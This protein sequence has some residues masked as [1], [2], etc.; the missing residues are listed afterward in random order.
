M[1]IYKTAVASD[2]IKII[3]ELANQIW[4]EHYPSIISVEQIEYMIS[5]RFTDETV[6]KHL[7]Q[8]II[9]EIINDGNRDIGY[10]SYEKDDAKFTVNLHQIYILTSEHGK[11]YGQ[12]TLHRVMDYGRD[13]N[14]EK[15]ELY[16][17]K[18]NAKAIKAYKRAGFVIV[19]EL[20]MDIGNGFIRDDYKMQKSLMPE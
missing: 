15:I 2:D 9:Y 19:E 18:K 10:L 11:G 1:L 14:L 12:A 8:G 4:R 16:V 5:R 6:T 3:R 7:Q 20:V 17:N 13:N